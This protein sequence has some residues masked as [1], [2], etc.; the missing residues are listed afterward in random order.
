MQTSAIRRAIRDRLMAMPIDPIHHIGQLSTWREVQFEQVEEL[1]AGFQH[2]HFIVDVG[3]VQSRHRPSREPRTRY[4]DLVL[5]YVVTAPATT[6][7]EANDRCLD[8][9][10]EVENHLAGDA[11]A[12]GPHTVRVETWEPL[13]IQA[14]GAQRVWAAQ[15]RL[16]VT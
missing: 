16:M 11:P 14:V 2:L 13:G 5:S 7:W 8:L 12:Y 3:R 9:M 6:M 1:T 10:E 4:L 15:M